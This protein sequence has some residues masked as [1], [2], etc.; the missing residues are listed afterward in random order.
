MEGMTPTTS[1]TVM[2]VIGDIPVAEYMKRT[3]FTI[4]DYF[5]RHHKGYL[6]KKS[7]AELKK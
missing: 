1:T 2:I 7:R 5:K 3:G 4:S 6:G